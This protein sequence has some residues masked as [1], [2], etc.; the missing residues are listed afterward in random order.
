MAGMF[1][2]PGS[3]AISIEKYAT[4]FVSVAHPAFDVITA[5]LPPL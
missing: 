3:S 2:R 1:S 5:D 4:A